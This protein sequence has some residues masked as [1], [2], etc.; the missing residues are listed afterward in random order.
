[1]ININIIIIILVLLSSLLTIIRVLQGILPRGD[2]WILLSLFIVLVTAF[3]YPINLSLSATIGAILSVLLLLL[4]QWAFKRINHLFE[5]QS[6]QKSRRLLSQLIGL[7]PTQYWRN[8][9]R[10]LFALELADKG[11]TKKAISLLT[12]NHNILPIFNYYYRLFIYEI[13]GDWGNCLQWFTDKVDRKILQKDPLLLTYYI[14]TLGETDQL[15]KLS[16]EIFTV[17]SLLIKL[18]KYSYISRLKLY[19][20]AFSG[21][22]LPM[23]TLFRTELSCYP[24][25][26]QLFWLVTAKIVR[27]KNKD[28]YQKLLKQ[29]VHNHYLLKSSIQWRLKTKSFPLNLKKNNNSYKFFQNLNYNQEKIKRNQ[30]LFQLKNQ[31]ITQ[32]FILLNFL[33]F[34]IQIRFGGSEN[35]E[36]LYQLGALVPLVVWSGEFWRLIT[37]NFLHYGWGHFLMNMLA[38]YFM[39]NLLESLSN[40]Y[41]YIIIYLISGIGSM[42]TFSY[43]AIYTNQLDYILVGA[44]ASIMGLVGSLTAI[45]IRKWLEHK[46]PINAKRVM[47][48]TLIISLQLISDTVIPQV[49]MLS[50]LFGLLIGFVIQIII[51]VLKY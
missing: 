6:Y 47:V 4:P 12:H 40:K 39:G 3:S 19:A 38:L 29:Y 41:Q 18:K 1:M 37:A 10:L 17:Q 20:F 46:S 28:S 26:L 22:I 33:V 43:V 30:K 7:H 50:H 11:N 23:K 36:T 35:L 24:R 42:L 31:K 8:Y 45:L 34:I 5:I 16:Q 15:D 44:S 51:C 25:D 9:L 32:F 49:S 2:G 27:D 21:Q 13:L 14:R 48:M